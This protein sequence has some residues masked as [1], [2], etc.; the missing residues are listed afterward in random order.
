MQAPAEQ[1]VVA[2]ATGALDTCRPVI[3]ELPGQRPVTEPGDGRVEGEHGDRHSRAT[4][5]QR[6]VAHDGLTHRQRRSARA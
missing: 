1:D 5:L 3:G 4:P 6:G 2:E